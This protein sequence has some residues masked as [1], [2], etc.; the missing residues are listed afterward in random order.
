MELPFLSLLRNKDIAGLHIPMIDLLLMELGKP[1]G[2]G[3]DKKP[4]S[5]ETLKPFVKVPIHLLAFFR[6]LHQQK[7]LFDSKSL[8]SLNQAHNCHRKNI[9][10]LEA[11]S[12]NPSPAAL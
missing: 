1:L 12:C 11:I 10:Y 5:L 2:K 4:S 6:R 9:P 8:P 7:A 3:P